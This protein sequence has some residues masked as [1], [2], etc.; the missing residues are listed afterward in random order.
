MIFSFSRQAGGDNPISHWIFDLFGNLFS[1]T[2][3]VQTSFNR[4]KL[5]SLPEAKVLDIFGRRKKT[6]IHRY[7]LFSNTQK[8]VVV[9]MAS[10]DG[11][12]LIFFS[13]E[14]GVTKVVVHPPN[15]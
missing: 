15:Y 11:A 9:S 3:P 6:K 2:Q 1:D 8:S 5:L 4:H 14:T 13:H 10:K 7:L 12:A